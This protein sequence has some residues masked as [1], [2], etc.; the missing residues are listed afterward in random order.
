LRRVQLQCIPKRA[1]EIGLIVDA[2]SHPPSD[3]D[4]GGIQRV[5]DR[6]GSFPDQ[7]GGPYKPVAHRGVDLCCGDERISDPRLVRC[8]RHPDRVREVDHADSGLEAPTFSADGAFHALVAW[9][10][11]AQMADLAGVPV[12]VQDRV[13]HC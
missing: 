11:D 4:A 13:P 8:V 9:D 1:Q 3:D 6:G 10:V 7:I 2:A 12:T 5:D